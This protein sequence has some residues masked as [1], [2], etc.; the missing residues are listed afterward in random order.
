MKMLRLVQ[1]LKAPVHQYYV[2]SPFPNLPPI[3]TVGYYTPKVFEQVFRGN[4]AQH[5]AMP[6]AYREQPLW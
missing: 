5:N 2:L 6:F 3:L 1:R 4:N